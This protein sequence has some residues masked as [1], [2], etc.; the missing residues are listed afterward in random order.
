MDLIISTFYAGVF[1]HLWDRG[2]SLGQCLF[3]PLAAGRLLG[4][5]LFQVANNQEPPHER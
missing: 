5:Y 3:W 1:L 4:A 2:R